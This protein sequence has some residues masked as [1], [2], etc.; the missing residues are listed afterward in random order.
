VDEAMMIQTSQDAPSPDHEAWVR[1]VEKTLEGRPLES[2]TYDSRD[3]LPTQ[4]LY[5][6]ADPQPDAV[7]FGL[8]RSQ[9]P[10]R[11]DVRTVIA[12]P[13]PATANAQALQD[14]ENG[15]NSLL[16]RLDPTGEDGVAVGSAKDL[17]RL[18]AGV[19]LELAPVALDAGF[20]GPTAARWLHA[21]ARSAPRA[22][23]Q[24]HL[25]PLGAF[26]RGGVSPG[27]VAAHVAEAATLATRLHDTYPE[28]TAFLASGQVLH[29]AG[30]TEA[31]ELAM[32]LSAALAYLRASDE[33]GAPL[34][35]AATMVVL[36][37]AADAE[38]FTTLA[39]HRAARALWARLSGALGVSAPARIEARSARRML[40]RLDPWV[41]LL[42]LTAAGFGAA[43]GGADA[44]VLEPFTQPLG[45]PTDFARRQARNAQLV[46]ME[47]SG[48]A[49]VED[50]AGGCWFLEAQTDQLARAAWRRFQEIERAGGLQ[51]ALEAGLVASWAEQGR[52]DLAEA[53]ASGARKLIGVSVFRNPQASPV[54]VDAAEAGGFARPSPEVRQPGLD[55]T[56]PPL[57]PWRVAEASEPEAA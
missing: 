40:A 33:A 42:R 9:G 53:V 26:A 6:A 46:L 31:Q 3:G 4:A 28:A 51:A 39:K 15:A 29:E 5:T 32:M 45:R 1:L 25:D 41:N 43:V 36:G 27:P 23:L 38:Y 56:C 37:L 16:M 24:L 54:A 19:E 20:L 7:R 11:W 52:R 49:R 12:H 34:Q 8:V 44:L 55:S 21:A 10:G 47:E 30:G 57:H 14:L 50:P 22:K 48:L 13:D 18:V 2:L 17:A 35:A